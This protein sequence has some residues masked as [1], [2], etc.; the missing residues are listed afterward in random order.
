MSEEEA[1]ASVTSYFYLAAKCAVSV[2][3]PPLLCQGRGAQHLTLI[4]KLI[5]K[6]QQH[7]VTVL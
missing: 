1:T 6:A 3:P 4:D 5:G 2:N 7:R